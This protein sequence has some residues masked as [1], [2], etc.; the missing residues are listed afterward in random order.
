[1]KSKKLRESR[2]RLRKK[3]KAERKMELVLKHKD[4]GGITFTKIALSVLGKAG[5]A[6]G[7]RRLRERAAKAMVSFGK[8]LSCKKPQ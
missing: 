7:A 1:M 8:E 2:E 6:K 3:R 5:V 4:L